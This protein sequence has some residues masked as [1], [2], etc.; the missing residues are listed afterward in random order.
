MKE[1]EK[2]KYLEILAKVNPF[3][4]ITPE[5]YLL[6][7]DNP[8]EAYYK[9]LLKLFMECPRGYIDLPLMMYTY[10]HVA[11]IDAVR[12]CRHK[13]IFL[14]KS[15]DFSDDVTVNTLREVLSLMLEVTSV[16]FDENAYQGAMYKFRVFFV[17]NKLDEST[18]KNMVEEK[19]YANKH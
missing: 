4:L 13:E 7:Y 15:W 2:N 12:Y 5:G 9:M 1:K 3:G 17:Q 11:I 14:L 6:H 8:V 18:Q 19:N 16:P 10:Q